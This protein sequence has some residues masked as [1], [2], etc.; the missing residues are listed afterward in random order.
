MNTGFIY[1]QLNVKESHIISSLGS[2]L[3]T[4]YYCTTCEFAAGFSTSQLQILS[5]LS[6]GRE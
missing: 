4:H 6:D 3:L 1:S 2:H 5:Q